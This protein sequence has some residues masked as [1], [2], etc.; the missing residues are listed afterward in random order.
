M[1]SYHFILCCPLLLLPSVLP[2]KGVFSIESILHISWLKY[3]SFSFSICPSN[4]YKGWF[5]LELIG[6]VSLLSKELSGVFSSTIVWKHQF[7]GAQSSL[8]SNCHLYMTAGKTIDGPSSAKWCLSLSLFF[9]FS[10]LSRASLVA[11]TVKD[12]GYLGSIPGLGTS[13]GGR[14]GNPHHYSCLENP[15]EQRKLADHSCKL[16]KS[17]T[18]WSN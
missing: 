3:W 12:M 8:W 14:Y 6:L 17:L 10:M 1:L 16:A 9:F 7:F 5:P 18:W 13:P 15:C 2:S 11:Q 4:E